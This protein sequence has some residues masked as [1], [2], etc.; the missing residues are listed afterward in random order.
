[1][2]GL[3]ALGLG[4]IV[5]LAGAAIFAINLFAGLSRRGKPLSIDGVGIMLVGIGLNLL[6]KW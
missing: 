3:G 2:G 4:K 1:M 6:L 5:F